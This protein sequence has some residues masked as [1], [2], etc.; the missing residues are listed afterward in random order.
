[1][2]SFISSLK[3][4]ETIIT[5][6]F[7]YKPK[8]LYEKISW[9]P[10]LSYNFVNEIFKTILSFLFSLLFAFLG[11]LK[12]IVLRF[13][14]IILC[15]LMLILSLD[16][17]GLA[18]RM[19]S[20]FVTLAS[21]FQLFLFLSDKGKLNLILNSVIYILFSLFMSA[22]ITK[23]LL[24]FF[25]NLI[26]KFIVLSFQN[27]S[28]SKSVLLVIGIILNYID[29]SVYYLLFPLVFL[30]FIQASELKIKFK[31]DFKRCLTEYLKAV[32]P[33]LHLYN[34]V[35]D[36]EN[37]CW[38][39]ICDTICKSEKIKIKCLL[40]LHNEEVG[41]KSIDENPLVER[42]YH[43]NKQFNFGDKV[44]FEFYS[45]NYDTSINSE[46]TLEAKIENSKWGK[47]EFFI[48]YSDLYSSCSKMRLRETDFERVYKV[49]SLIHE[50]FSHNDSEKRLIPT[51]HIYKTKDS[52]LY[53]YKTKR[54]GIW[55]EEFIHNMSFSEI[56]DGIT[57]YNKSFKYKEL[58]EP[59]FFD[60]LGIAEE[61]ILED[62]GFKR[63]LCE[64]LE[65]YSK[66]FFGAPRLDLITKF[67]KNGSNFYF[68]KEIKSSRT[69]KLK[70]EINCI[71]EEIVK[72]LDKFKNKNLKF[73]YFR[74][75]GLSNPRKP[76]DA[77]Q[78]IMDRTN[79]FDN[80]EQYVDSDFFQEM[81]RLERIYLK[82]PLISKTPVKLLNT[83]E[84][85]KILTTK[86]EPVDLKQMTILVE[87]E[88]TEKNKENVGK[89]KGFFLKS[90]KE[91]VRRGV[92]TKS[93]N[94]KQ[95]S[96]MTDILSEI[97]EV[98]LMKV[99]AKSS[100]QNT[101]NEIKAL[102][103][104]LVLTRK[105][106]KKYKGN[107][108][109]TISKKKSRNNDNLILKIKE[110]E[111]KLEALTKE[112]EIKKRIL[113][114]WEDKLIEKN[115][116]KDLLVKIR[117]KEE[118]REVDEYYNSINI[119]IL[120]KVNYVEEILKP[121]KSFTPDNRYPFL[122]PLE[123]FTQKKKNNK[124]NKTSKSNDGFLELKKKI[125]VYSKKLKESV[126]KSEI[127]NQIDIDQNYYKILG[128][129]DNEDRLGSCEGLEKYKI[130]TTL[131][132]KSQDSI[133]SSFVKKADTLG[134]LYKVNIDKRLKKIEEKE[135]KK[136]KG[137]VENKKEEEGRKKVNVKEGEKE[138]GSK[139]PKGFI[140]EFFKNV[141][142]SRNFKRKYSKNLGAKEDL[143]SG[144]CQHINHLLGSL[145]QNFGNYISK[146]QK[147]ISEITKQGSY[148]PLI[149][150]GL[151]RFISNLCLDVGFD[152]KLLINEV[153]KSDKEISEL[154][155][156]FEKLNF[157]IIDTFL[158]EILRE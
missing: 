130:S 149:Y 3:C 90:Y 109:E 121:L 16:K 139:D 136:R 123:N 42:N 129:W 82:P 153:I 105:G 92:D 72:K 17:Y 48:S 32:D 150:G 37:G 26:N 97:D 157:S 33:S 66:D 43:Q 79:K 76:S 36:S 155:I 46:M 68:C 19:F 1:M 57:K 119:A 64:E 15:I 94:R 69:K 84:V 41:W 59:K 14:S 137:K 107:P 80:P 158:F 113:K 85:K 38:Y 132:K 55:E 148:K 154:D 116:E 58:N 81:K 104:S 152:L 106:I 89:L 151:D 88:A 56:V 87:K 102:D 115:E 142:K 40:S 54:K 74:F 131:Y 9:F 4:S 62:L 18:F 50:S 24:S 111:E 28:L 99:R 98:H 35:K 114:D 93:S 140:K 103:E 6:Y 12:S 45:E 144:P 146:K 135:K 70:F 60:V 34:S 13:V 5:H 134:D 110:Y 133:Y 51:D 156:E 23:N 8:S 91:A 63:K 7:S 126:L 118:K 138:E 120:S 125:T 100:L 44:Y 112:R 122:E 127:E 73:N 61:F 83:K 10:S 25:I 108:D 96:S 31:A 86:I 52:Y 53:F 22:F 29:S 20:F 145:D 2:N 67:I 143:F 141:I 124:G 39:I 95:S 77:F 47:G 21:S 78:K 128:E 30:S 27:K 101:V 49:I 65:L 147:I 75:I 71:L 11:L 117:E